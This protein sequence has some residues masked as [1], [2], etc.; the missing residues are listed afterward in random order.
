MI[1]SGVADLEADGA[2]LGRRPADEAEPSAAAA[3]SDTAATPQ[4]RRSRLFLPRG[5]RHGHARLRA[6]FRDPLE[7]QLDV[8]RRLEPVLRVLGEARLD[9]RLTAGG[10]IG[11]ISVTEV[12]SSRRIAPA[13]L[14]WLLPVNAFFPVAI[15]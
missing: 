4:A 11:A 1:P 6:A 12:G 3:T 7:L 5:D 2:R 14:A 9:D 13:R 15:S 10:I 8:V